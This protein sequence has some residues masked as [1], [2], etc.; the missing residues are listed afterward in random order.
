M[1]KDK[2]VLKR[3][4]FCGADAIMRELLVD[5]RKKYTT[6][7]YWIQCKNKVSIINKCSAQTK[8]CK[9][10]Q[11]AIKAWNTRSNHDKAKSN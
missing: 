2:E 8:K 10:K 1:K 11:Q 6:Y 9:T 5:A 3:C 4:P 7:L